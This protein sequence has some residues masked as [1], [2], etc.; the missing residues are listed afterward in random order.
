MCRA[1]RF[2]LLLF[3]RCRGGCRRRRRRCRCRR[4]RRRRISDVSR[5]ADDADAYS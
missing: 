4:R 1:W 2:V 3:L 5:V